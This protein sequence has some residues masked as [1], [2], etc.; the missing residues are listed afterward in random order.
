MDVWVPAARRF[1]R[2]NPGAPDAVIEVAWKDSYPGVSF[3]DE[4]G[5]THTSY[6]FRKIDNTRLFMTQATVWSY[7]EDAQF[8]FEA[9]VIESA[10]FRPDGYA[11]RAIDDRSSDQIR[12]I[13]YEDVP[14]DTNWEPVPEF[15][16]RESVARYDR[17]APPDADVHRGMDSW[18]QSRHG[19]LTGFRPDTAGAGT[20]FAHSVTI[21]LSCIDRFVGPESVQSGRVMFM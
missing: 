16:H 1:R 3:V 20:H 2:G 13:E 5:R 17:D 8:E 10:E 4:K 12:Q 21:L 11:S 19:F 14:V 9:S 18:R 7:P 15:G 6:D